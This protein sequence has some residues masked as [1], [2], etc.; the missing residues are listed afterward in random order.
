MRRPL[1]A[2][3]DRFVYEE[4]TVTAGEDGLVGRWIVRHNKRTDYEIRR[5]HI[6]LLQ[7]SYELITK[8]C[9]SRG[10]Y[11]SWNDFPQTITTT[12]NHAK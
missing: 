6:T 1:W 10:D 7:R 2:T 5:A 11:I 8:P 3:R 9:S 12:V 4:V